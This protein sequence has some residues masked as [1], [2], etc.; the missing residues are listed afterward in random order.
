MRVK[1]DPANVKPNTDEEERADPEKS[2]LPW[3]AEDC[4]ARMV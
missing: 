2:E 4:T 1:I 3:T